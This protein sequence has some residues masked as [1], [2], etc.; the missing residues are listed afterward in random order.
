MWAVGRGRV[1]VT[2]ET[3][4]SCFC[5]YQS[6]DKESFLCPL[7]ASPGA[8]VYHPRLPDPP[9]SSPTLLRS[10][11]WSVSILPRAPAPQGAP[12]GRG[13]KFWVV[14]AP[15]T[16]GWLGEGM[17]W[18]VQV[19]VKPLGEN[20]LLTVGSLPASHSGG[21]WR[22]PGVSGLR[23]EWLAGIFILVLWY[24]GWNPA[25]HASRTSVLPPNYIP[26]LLKILS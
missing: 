26:S 2:R 11:C 13:W 18:L 14:S 15:S 23:G 6:P 21:V 20:L 22:M 16:V 9:S 8:S 12:W 10:P 1:S 4:S 5:L 25:S 17:L 7:P 24:R 19:L 3:C